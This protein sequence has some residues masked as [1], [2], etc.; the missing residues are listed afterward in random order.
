M[1]KFQGVLKSTDV[2]TFI[3]Y[4]KAT[5]LR[6]FNHMQLCCQDGKLYQRAKYLK[7]LFLNV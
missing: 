3:F 6:T 2:K 7:L 4:K 5:I 1:W